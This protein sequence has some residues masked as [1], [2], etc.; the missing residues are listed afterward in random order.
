MTVLPAAPLSPAGS[1][2]AALA[3]RAG[4]GWGGGAGEERPGLHRSLAASPQLLPR[5]LELVN[6]GVSLRRRRVQRRR[7]LGEPAA[8]AP[9]LR[10]SRAACA[11]LLGSVRVPRSRGRQV[12]PH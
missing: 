9:G 5:P 8:E 6:R 12:Q 2:A 1:S 10:R 4:R 7:V 11:A 3:A